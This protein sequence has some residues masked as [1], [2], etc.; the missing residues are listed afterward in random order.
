MK[1]ECLTKSASPNA[2]V[3][4]TIVAF[5]YGGVAPDKGNYFTPSL[6]ASNFQEVQ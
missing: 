3:A 1:T 5:E 6:N 2:A 4:T